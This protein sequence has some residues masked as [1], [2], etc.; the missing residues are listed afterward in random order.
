MSAQTQVIGNLPIT[1]P[2]S[3]EE[4]DKGRSL[5]LKHVQQYPIVN[6]TKSA[7]YSIPYTKTVVHAVSPTLKTLREIQPIKLAVDTGDS[8][9]DSV[10]NQ[11]DKFVPSLKTLEVNHLTGPITRPINGA[12]EEVHNVVN[13]VNTTVND[14]VN[15]TLVEPV[16]KAAE[17]IK[18]KIHHTVYDDATGKSIITTQADALVGPFN[19]TLEKFIDNHFPK[20]AKVSKVDGS[21]ELS[22]TVK[23]VANV[24]SGNKDKS[25]ELD[26]EKPIAEPIASTEITSNL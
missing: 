1:E 21:S 14:K 23:I 26:E 12:V 7:I 8:L 20:T 25:G 5:F 6:S 22:R 17:D 4:N 2:A 9:A 16:S 19:E 11:V 24:V 13:S 18:E 15:K 3:S 10:L